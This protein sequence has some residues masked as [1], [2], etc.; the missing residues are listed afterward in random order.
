MQWPENWT[1][2]E[3]CWLKLHHAFILFF[4]E[5]YSCTATLVFYSTW[6]WW[7]WAPSLWQDSF[8]FRARSGK[9]LCLQ[10][11]RNRFQEWNKGSC[12]FKALYLNQC[13]QIMYLQTSLFIFWLDYMWPWSTK[14]VLSRWGIFVAIA[15]N[16]L[17]G[18]KLSIFL[19]C[20]KS[21]EY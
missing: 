3:S 5:S 12:L 10:V 8:F 20:Q 11:N 16:T 15:K 21:L 1:T 18:S 13:A 9:H 6:T 2:D 17:Y 19:L 4:S 7:R 14:A